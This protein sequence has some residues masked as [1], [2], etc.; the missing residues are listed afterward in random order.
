MVN[1]LHNLEN[2]WP[3]TAF[4]STFLSEFYTQ[5]AYMHGNQN[6]QNTAARNTPRCDR[7]TLKGDRC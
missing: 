4:N 2:L 1:L 6:L 3:D 7:E 5:M